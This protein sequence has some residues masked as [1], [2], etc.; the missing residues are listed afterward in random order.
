MIDEKKIDFLK[1]EEKAEKI[2]EL[3]IKTVS[4]TGGH[5]APN[6]GIVELTLAI[7]EIF[8]FSKDK[9][10]F[11]VGH[12][13]YV[14]KII[15]GREDRF[16]TLRQREGLA[17]F[18]DPNESPYDHFISGHA[19]TALS[20]ACGIAKANPNSKVVVVIGDASIA[21]GH[22]L[23]A[24]N[25]MSEDCKNIIVILN[26]NE[27][28]IG[29]NVGALSKFLGKAMVSDTYK[30]LKKDIRFFINNGSIGKKI[31]GILERA[32]ESIKYFLSPL[33]IS[34]MIGFKFL[35]TLD[36]HNL[37]ELTN[38][39]TKAKAE[40]GPI[41]IHVKTQKGR[42]YAFA[43]QDAE[44]FHGVSPFNLETGKIGTQLEESYSSIFGRKMVDMAKTDSEIIL[45]SAAMI[46]GVGAG[47]FFQ[48]Y[49][50]RSKDIGMSE[51]HGVTYCAG[52]AIA[53]KN[54][55]FAIYSTFMQRGF[56]QLIHDV[57]LQKISVKFIVDRAGIVGEDGKTHNGL[58]DIS[59]FTKIP[60]FIV[61]AP[62]TGHELEEILEETK[63][64]NDKSVMIRYP[65]GASYNYKFSEKF[66]I[67][68]WREIKKGNSAL[69][70]ATGSMFGEILDV[71]K[72]LEDIGVN[73]TIVSAASI[74]PL[75]YKYITEE[76]KKYK[77]IFVLEEAYSKGSFGSEILEFLNK[78]NIMKKIHIIALDNNAIPHGSRDILMKE[79][80]LR[81]DE[82]IDR[83]KR[84]IDVQQ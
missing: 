82:L 11:D 41:F 80:G 25:N 18:T 30:N 9:I 23:E 14:H 34:E 20:A 19:G 75:D 45:V 28:S 71:E 61:F 2:R 27:M 49:P 12:Q 38:Y 83:M 10:L 39:F 31:T 3:L 42:G 66:I 24:L 8:D 60:N 67:G 1:L 73:A 16:S 52:L 33:S 53:G 58:Y 63:N 6:L 4:K 59:M 62:T 22:S 36:G 54:P 44:K 43:E 56:S 15:T 84:C 51:G 48:K 76:F 70:I 69:I 46:K 21:N 77:D 65:K 40:E 26:D 79:N 7:H 74:K 32:E 37:S 13:S 29:K 17:P 50:E 35:G 5:L 64:I 68:K 57:S 47:E 81:G 55:Y 72:R 78:E